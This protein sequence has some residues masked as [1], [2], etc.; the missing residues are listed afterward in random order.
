M[1]TTI[2]HPVFWLVQYLDTLTL[3]NQCM[4]R[5]HHEW[6]RM[7][8]NWLQKWPPSFHLLPSYALL[9]KGGV[10]TD[11]IF[12]LRQEASRT[13]SVGWSV[14]LSMSKQ[15]ENNY[16]FS[17]IW[18]Y[19]AQTKFTHI[20]NLWG[21]TVPACTEPKAYVHSQYLSILWM[22]FAKILNPA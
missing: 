4:I 19:S 9:G 14:S 6:I 8:L 21:C 5:F 18:I 16:H 10:M 13:R 3:S 1:E 15:E 22:H 11:S 2:V 20:K 17:S 12:M 7:Q